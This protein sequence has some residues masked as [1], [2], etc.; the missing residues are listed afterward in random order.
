MTD[1]YFTM[2]QVARALKEGR[3]YEMFGTGTAATI[4]PIGEILYKGASELAF[5]IVGFPCCYY[6][7][8]LGFFIHFRSKLTCDDPDERLKVPLALE[9]SGKLARHYTDAIFD[10][11]VCVIVIIVLYDCD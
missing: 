1:G 4:A 8:V 2:P 7:P 11:H 5:V 10:I 9:N 6:S 3:V